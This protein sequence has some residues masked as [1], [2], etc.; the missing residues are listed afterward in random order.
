M[1]ASGPR[2]GCASGQE[3]RGRAAEA[4]GSARTVGA[5]DTRYCCTRGH[6]RAAAAA[7]FAGIQILETRRDRRR[8]A[9]FEHLREIDKRLQAVWGLDVP[10]VV[11]AIGA[12]YKDGTGPLSK[13]AR[14]YMSLLNALDLLARE[15]DQGAVDAM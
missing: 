4:G 5:I 7:T 13:D 15:M 11:E 10:A 2:P 14:S 6:T 3:T 8:A 12:A 1:L 9:T